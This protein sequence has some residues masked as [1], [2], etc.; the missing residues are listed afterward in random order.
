MSHCGHDHHHT[1]DAR[2]LIAAFCIISAFM[3]IEVVGGV[4]AGSLALL[5]DAGHMLTD[6]V[7]LAL[8]ASAQWIARKPADE[9]RHFGYRRSQVLAAFANGIGLMFLLVWIVYEAAMRLIAPS[10]VAWRPMLIV[11]SLG[12]LA[13]AV[14]FAVLHDASHRNINIRG[15]MLHVISDLLGS[16][17]AVIAAIVI[18]TSGW[19][20]IDPLL[21]ILVAALILRSAIALLRETG[22]ILL[23]GAPENINVQTLVSDMK[24][25]F[26]D[27]EDVHGVQI[28][29][30][31]PGAARLTMHVRLKTGANGD[32]AL[33]NLK[34]EL[35]DRYGVVETTIQIECTNQ[36]PDTL[37]R[38]AEM[39]NVSAP[40]TASLLAH[41]GAHHEATAG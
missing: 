29:Q 8:A 40:E 28:W 20:R 4:L 3:V 9:K 39:R 21:S 33:A 16:V 30:L 36:C 14:A 1:D 13:N 12:L 17:A 11:A 18:A 25:T 5:A 27:V 10:P 31:A 37:L 35:F 38:S 26:V 24:E 34:Q 7:A 41:A 2:R 22:H 23:E 19:T 15:A 32:A 6:T